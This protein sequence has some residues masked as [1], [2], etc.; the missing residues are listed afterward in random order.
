[1][2]RIFFWIVAIHIIGGFFVLSSAA[3]A[4]NSDVVVNEIGAYKSSGHEWI[5]IWNRGSDAID[6]YGWK[7]YE[8]GVNHG[9]FVSTT[10]N[11]LASNEY[12][13]ICQDSEQFVIDY[14]EFNGSI[15]DSSWG[16]LNEDGEEIGL[17]DAEGNMIEQFSYI[18]SP[19]YSL[20]RANPYVAVYDETNWRTHTFGDSLGVI[21]SNFSTSTSG[22]SDNETGETAST[23]SV[24]DA[25]TSTPANN[26]W[27]VWQKIKINEFVSDPLEGSEWVELFNSSTSS[28]DLTGGRIC[29][30][31]ETTSTCKDLT[32]TILPGGWLYYD[33]LSNSY[34][35]NSGD[36][37]VLLSPTGQVVDRVDYSGVN[38]PKKRESL[39]R[40]IDGSDT[41]S[42]SDWGITTALTPSAANTIV[43]SA[44]SPASGG[45][46][47]HAA[48][49]VA[50]SVATESLQPPSLLPNTNDSI[51]I[52]EIFPNPLGSDVEGEYIEIFN[53]SSE[54]I[55]LVG[56]KLSDSSR[57]YL[58]SGT[59]ESGQYV[60]YKRSTTGIALNNSGN[61]E[62]KLLDSQG[63]IVD[64]VTYD[65]APEG[66]SFARD[67]IG[68]WQWT[69][70]QTPGAENEIITAPAGEIN[71]II[72]APLSG[73][74][75]EMLLF[76][77]EGSTDAKGGEIQYSW[78][79]GDGYIVFG[80]EVEHPFATSGVYSII[81]SATSSSGI[82]GQKHLSVNIGAGL[83]SA[84]VE[85][86]IN[87]ILANPEEDEQREYIE[88]KNFGA[89]T[90]DVSGWFLKLKNNKEY[91]IPDNTVISPGG[92]LLLYRT[93]TK[94]AINN[95]GDMVSLLNRSGQIVDVVKF[96]KTKEGSSYSLLED[97]WY[98][99]SKLTPGQENIADKIESGGKSP[100]VKALAQKKYFKP[101][102]IAEAREAEAGSMV[103]V[104]GVVSVL[105]GVF[106]SQYFY[107]QE[108]GSGIQVYSFKKDF[109]T[110]REGDYL[111][112]EGTISEPQ[113]IKRL[114]INSNQSINIIRSGLTINAATSGDDN[115]GVVVVA[116][117]E[118][119]ELKSN[120]MYLDNGTVESKIYFKK[121]ANIDR[122]KFK[123]GMDV[124]ARGILE[125]NGSDYEL[126]PRSQVDINIVD[127]SASSSE[128]EIV[129]TPS[130]SQSDKAK[131]YL[132]ATAGGLVAL[133]L[134]FVGRT[135]NIAIKSGIKKIAV[136]V[137]G[138]F[139][140]V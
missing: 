96:G 95:S 48:P 73:E 140:K 74:I 63:T 50:D 75:G 133:L 91:Q 82:A 90:A 32:G 2:R 118:I 127:I 85:V 27:S 112:V 77:A 114:K 42:N 89:E 21:N 84:R 13:V 33:L 57:S 66:E 31:R 3:F 128:E 104:K 34:L 36:S 53:K 7:F 119:T 137:I 54:R 38:I 102:S 126:W 116:G 59:I 92:L 123:V 67:S 76:D 62:A 129:L 115:V 15:F 111:E 65:F 138:L 86:S 100:P 113:G 101:V 64:L 9:L 94:F 4:A 87:E 41:D 25:P 39:A 8:N 83:S 105:P 23:P 70:S 18:A 29:D 98:W 108:E 71:W 37:A 121:G 17:K 97:E 139:K 44:V 11:Y 122:K 78:N 35:N 107:I 68:K 106:G 124:E 26:D 131:K 12:A 60:F 136:L 80:D 40:L 52:N 125:I 110:L 93:I 79:F 16:S 20:E 1:M 46:G 120:Y 14:P 43:R 22:G 130:E 58:L 56:W 88:I 69:S 5:E 72:K 24:E 45:G 135:K 132:S 28:I 134:G 49:V 6:L 47:V 99:T 55:S 30:S 109:P 81:I 61:E 19:N 103:A 10:D 51:F 117:G